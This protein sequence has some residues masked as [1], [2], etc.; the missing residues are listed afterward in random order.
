MFCAI[1][2][3]LRILRLFALQ[4]NNKRKNRGTSWQAS[5]KHSGQ[6]GDKYLDMH[7]LSSSND[8]SKSTK[9]PHRCVCVR[10]VMHRMKL[11]VYR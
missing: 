8:T 10:G 2:P 5:S 6:H 9:H 7:I 1:S 11:D 3:A 4:P